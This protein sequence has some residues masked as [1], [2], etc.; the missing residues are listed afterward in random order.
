MYQCLLFDLKFTFGIQ[1]SIVTWHVRPGAHIEHLLMT[2]NQ[3]Y[4]WIYKAAQGEL[5]RKMTSAAA[6][7]FLLPFLG[8]GSSCASVI[9]FQTIPFFTGHWSILQSVFWSCHVWELKVYFHHCSQNLTTPT[10]YVL[11][12]HSHNMPKNIFKKTLYIFISL[13]W[14]YTRELELSRIA[15]NVQLGDRLAEKQVFKVH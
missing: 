1:L 8:N 13:D 6:L 11:G 9:Y 15:C 5:N 10:M 2:T 3:V 12:S 4:S 14:V 7:L